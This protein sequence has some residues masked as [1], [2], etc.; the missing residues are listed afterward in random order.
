MSKERNIIVENHKFIWI[1][2]KNHIVWIKPNKEDTSNPLTKPVSCD[3]GIDGSKKLTIKPAMIAKWI[4]ENIFNKEWSGPSSPKVH[5]NKKENIIDTKNIVSNTIDKINHFKKENKFIVYK[6][7][8]Y[9]FDDLSTSKD[10]HVVGIANTKEKASMIKDLLE[11]KNDLSK[12]E[13][14][15]PK[16]EIHFFIIEE[17]IYNI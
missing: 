9:V 6:K 5:I 10:V 4:T 8:I 3:V 13:S 1:V 17:T 14:L 11:S 16:E 2:G 12:N 7:T 15:D